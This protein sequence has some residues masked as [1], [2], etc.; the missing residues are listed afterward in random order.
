VCVC[1]CVCVYY[2]DM[3]KLNEGDNV[4]FVSIEEISDK[5]LGFPPLELRCVFL[6]VCMRLL[7]KSD[8]PLGFSHPNL[9]S[10]IY[11]YVCM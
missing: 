10:Y 7:K 1:V 6:C 3:G 9:R 11:Y 4:V 5:P 2:I 8:Q